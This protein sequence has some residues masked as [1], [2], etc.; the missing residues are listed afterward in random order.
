MLGAIQGELVRRQE[1]LR[2][3][4]NYGSQRDYERART[5]GVPLAPLPSLLLIVDEFSE[6]LQA[7]PDF[8]DMFVQIGRVGRSLGVHLLLA[9]QRLEEGRLRGLDTH[10]SY[11]IGLRTFSAMESRVVLG[12]PDA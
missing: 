7:R 10:L 2:D 9:S 1:L 6:L 4:G 3:A 8:I 12:V 5:S 11:R